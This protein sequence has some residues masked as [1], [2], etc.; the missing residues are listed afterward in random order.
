MESVAVSTILGFIED[1]SR[2][3]SGAVTHWILESDR[4]D[5]DNTITGIR[6]FFMVAATCDNHAVCAT[7]LD[8][9][10]IWSDKKVLVYAVNHGRVDIALSSL[11]TKVQNPGFTDLFRLLFPIAV[12][13]EDIDVVNS[14][15]QFS[16]LAM[17]HGLDIA[18]FAAR[19]ASQNG[20]IVAFMKF[21]ERFSDDASKEYMDV[22]GSIVD[23]ENYHIIDDM[24][25]ALQIP[26]QPKM[27]K[28]LLNCL[29]TAFV[30]ENKV[31]SCVLQERE[32][33]RYA[34]GE[35]DSSFEVLEN[36]I[37]DRN[38]RAAF[39]WK[40]IYDKNL[41]LGIRLLSRDVARIIFNMIYFYR[42]ESMIS[43]L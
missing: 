36:I 39:C 8:E 6:F 13:S 32:L 1:H 28:Y 16:D 41:V 24:V 31:I 27:Y 26:L 20:N 29:N 18:R 38:I 3:A 42:I 19:T 9:D 17:D 25:A 22:L 23:N 40:W 33:F 4:L 12:I 21:A 5:P 43:S 7:L 2:L 15:D 37:R 30:S 14:T 34:L 10:R 11:R 35:H